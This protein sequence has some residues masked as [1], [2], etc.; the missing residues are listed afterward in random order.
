M[1]ESHGDQGT[2]FEIGTEFEAEGGEIALTNDLYTDRAD[3]NVADDL[4][5]ITSLH[6]KSFK[7]FEDFEISLGPF[8]VL[9]GANNSGKSSVLRAIR[10]GFE[11]T[12]LHFD[13]YRDDKAV[14]LP[15][16]SVPRALLPVAQLRDLW[17]GGRM[18]AGNTW[19]RSTIGMELKQGHLLQFG[20]IGPWNAA[21]SKIE[22][23][24]LQAMQ[25][26]PRRI[27]DPFLGRPPKLV[28]PSIGIVAEEEYRTPA[29]RATLVAT[30]RHNEI[31]RN[32]LLE[33][34]PEQ[35]EELGEVLQSYF[36]AHVKSIEFD[37]QKDPFISA[38]Y[39][40]G[41]YEHDLYSAG[42]GFLQVVEVLAFIL[43]GN[44]S[45]ILLDE[46]DSHLNSAL[47]HAFVDIL[48]DL[49]SKRRCQVI[50]ATHSKEI[51][52]YV[53][54]SRLIHLEA[55]SQ[56]AT[57]LEPHASTVT[58]LKELGALDNVD[59]YQIVRQKSLLVV[60]GA[61]DRELLPRLA[62]RL[63]SSL[64]SGA[65]RVSIVPSRGA[66]RLAND[67]E[68]Q[69]VEEILDGPVACLLLRDRDGLTDAWRQQL[70]DLSKR[71]MYIWPL[72]C[73][74]SFLLRAA[75][76]HRILEGEIGSDAPSEST[77][78]TV[79]EGVVKA[80]REETVDRVATK[81]QEMEWTVNDNRL[82]PA[83]ANPMAREEV[84]RNWT[85]HATRLR[86]V[87]GKE[88]LKRVR[89]D[90]QD[91]TGVSFGNVRIVEAMSSDDV[92]DSIREMLEFARETLLS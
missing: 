58:I 24:D 33:L 30:G 51:I 50:M 48:E 79:I 34:S 28:P 47:Q 54:P 2:L 91:R 22:D 65:S 18:R 32:Y 16:R 25:R 57:N 73:L 26:I 87:S 85:S 17:P 40:T 29:R 43:Q 66:D 62:G 9:V 52:N 56:R 10:L 38:V 86:L 1:T 71:P 44:P 75:P 35:R 31:V 12:R 41:D 59:A 13:R 70:Q 72:D 55:G 14:F 78:Q 3:A 53:D 68:L 76:M 45:I 81:I 69:V 84:E 89:R 83:Q 36:G 88:A 46:P 60:E 19:I 80:L 74:E 64:F 21:T 5:A 42:G 11:L 63:G 20:I 49:A 15:G 61:T 82:T 6:L 8:N 92:N 4:S 23:S 27:L 67:A 90:V 39:A 37:E 7:G 77:I